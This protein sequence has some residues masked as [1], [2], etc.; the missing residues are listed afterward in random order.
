MFCLEHFAFYVWQ[1][2]LK[3]K[4]A[5]TIFNLCIPVNQF[6]Y[7]LTLCNQRRDVWRNRVLLLQ[8]NFY[9]IMLRLILL[10]FWADLIVILLSVGEIFATLISGNDFSPETQTSDPGF[11]LGDGAPLINDFN[12]VS[13]L[14]YLLFFCCKILLILESRRSSQWEKGCALPPRLP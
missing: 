12:L 13:C 7:L 10:R 14:F 1:N 4:R 3:T 8:F 5:H 11:F 2:C 9:W 6:G